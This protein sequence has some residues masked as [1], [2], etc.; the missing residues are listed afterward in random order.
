MRIGM[1]FQEMMLHK[2][3]V[4]ISADNSCITSMPANKRYHRKM[5]EDYWQNTAGDVFA[6]VEAETAAQAV[7]LTKQWKYNKS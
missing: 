7:E 1:R 6:Y 3:I 5:T 2:Y 4:F